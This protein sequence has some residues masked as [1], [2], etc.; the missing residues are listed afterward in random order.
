VST[1]V[2]FSGGLTD[3]DP[4]E[5]VFVVERSLM[6]V[7]LT[8]GDVMLFLIAA[9]LWVFVLFGTNLIS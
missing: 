9:A 7:T 4:R 5:R 1:P 3:G 2:V 8:F 6:A